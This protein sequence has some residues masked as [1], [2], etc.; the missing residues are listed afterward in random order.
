M[1]LDLAQWP[2][3]IKLKQL[4]LCLHGP[5]QAYFRTCSE[6]QKQNYSALVQAMSRRFTPVQIQAL[7]CSAF[8]ERKQGKKE[9]VDA[10]AQELQ[11]L[12]QRAYPS[13]ACGSA[14][15]QGW[16]RQF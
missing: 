1:V 12:F 16:G 14:D 6:E 8:H 7:K 15:A 2:E 3:Q 11:C 9:S 10:Y 5:A 4:A 13:A